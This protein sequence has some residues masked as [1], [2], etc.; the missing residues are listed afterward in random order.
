ME[1]KR[2]NMSREIFDLQREEADRY[3]S[4]FNLLNQEHGLI[5]TI[6]EMDD[7][8]IECAKIFNQ[9]VSKKA[10]QVELV[11]PFTSQEFI[12]TWEVLKNEP[13]WKKK[14]VKALQASLVFLSKHCHNEAIEI[15]EA[16]IRNGYQG[17]FELKNTKANEKSSSKI[18]RTTEDSIK[19]FITQNT[20]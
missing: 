2:N 8:I 13:K 6:S 1:L 7:I 16:S 3:Q 19:L 10:K 14:S 18:G 20:K 11:L 9:R 17:L 12:S 4:L 5:L 15:M